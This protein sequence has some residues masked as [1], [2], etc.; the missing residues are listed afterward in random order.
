MVSFVFILHSILQ[1]FQ[2]ILPNIE[3]LVDL[4]VSDFQI[5][6][7]PRLSEP[8]THFYCIWTVCFIQLFVPT[9]QN[10]SPIILFEIILF[11][12]SFDTNNWVLESSSDTINIFPRFLFHYNIFCFLDNH[13]CTKHFNIHKGT[14]FIIFSIAF[15]KHQI[16]LNYIT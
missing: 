16:G 8:F 3:N 12:I 5:N 10:S 14:S 6:S 4:C 9:I 1:L 13:F 7:I 2:S 15:Q 11:W